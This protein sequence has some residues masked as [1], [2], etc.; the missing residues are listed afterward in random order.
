MEVTNLTDFQKEWKNKISLRLFYL[1]TCMLLRIIPLISPSG[2]EGKD[3]ETEEKS[4][5]YGAFG[6]VALVQV[7]AP[8]PH[9]ASL[10]WDIHAYPRAQFLAEGREWCNLLPVGSLLLW[11]R[12]RYHTQCSQ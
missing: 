2:N 7:S 11:L 3:G 8:V 5:N 4:P 12:A 9:W 1:P 6:T 10:Q